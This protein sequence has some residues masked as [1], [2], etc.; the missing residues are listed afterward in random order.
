MKR[1]SWVENT[2]QIYLDYHDK[3][4]GVL[5]LDEHYLFEMLVLESFHTGLSWLIILKKR[6]DFEKAFDNFDVHKIIAYDDDKIKELMN[7]EKI[8]RNALKIKATIS[9]AKAFLVIQKEFGSFKNYLEGYFDQI[10]YQE[11]EATT[12]VYSDTISKDLKKRGFKFLGSV[13]LHSYLQAVGLINAH[14]EGCFLKNNK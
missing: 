12:S 6:K 1:C 5:N 3:E 13:T 4:W 9:N 10:Y 14:Q 7:N 2:P 8:V 11:D